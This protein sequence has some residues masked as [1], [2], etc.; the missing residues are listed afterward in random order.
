MVSLP[1]SSKA[2]VMGI[3]FVAH[4]TIV[5]PLVGVVSLPSMANQLGARVVGFSALLANVFQLL[6]VDLLLLQNK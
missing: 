4:V 2:G 6:E 1:V 5:A 3:V